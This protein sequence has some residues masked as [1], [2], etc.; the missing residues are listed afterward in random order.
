MKIQELLKEFKDE[1][2]ILIDMSWVMY[3]SH[4]A[5]Q[6]LTNQHGEQT[7]SFYGLGKAIQTLKESY[8]EAL[9]LLVDDGAPIER[10]ELDNNYKANREHTVHFTDKKYRVDCMIQNVPNVYRIYNPVIEADDLM[11][12]ISRIKDYQNQF[13]IYTSDKDLY[14]ALDESTWLASEISQGQL[15]LKDSTNDQYLKFFQDLQP[16]QV[17]FFRAVLG[18]PSDNLKIIRPRFPSKVAY[19]FAKN[20][21]SRLAD[22][23]TGITKPSSKP[24]DLTQKQYEALLEIY[25]SQEFINNLRLMKLKFNPTIPIVEKDKQSKEVLDVLH[26]LELHQ[27]LNWVSTQY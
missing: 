12:S 19:Y 1:Y 23:S 6:R 26:N 22:G 8:P 20:Y 25:S 14:Q 17:P 3:K 15:L 4:Y 21:V 5:F 7:G 11:F 18:D 27:F 9:I 24:K 10:K 16:F 2:V 13:I